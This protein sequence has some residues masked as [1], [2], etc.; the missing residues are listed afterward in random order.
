MKFDGK[1][2]ISIF[3]NTLVR[4]AGQSESFIETAKGLYPHWHR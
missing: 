2:F 1:K 3:V 4:E